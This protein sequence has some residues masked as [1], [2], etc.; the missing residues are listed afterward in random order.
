MNVKPVWPVCV[1]V[2]T[3]LQKIKHTK[4]YKYIYNMYIYIYVYIY[5]YIIYIYMMMMMNCFCGMVDRR[6]AY[7]LISS[8]DHC[9]SSSPSRICSRIWTCAEPEFST[10][11]MKLC[12]S[13]NYYTTASQI[14]I[15]IRLD[16]MIIYSCTINLNF[17]IICV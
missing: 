13:D 10:C 6:K 7:S 8:W 15:Y 3:M 9:Q 5:I 4:L 12:S 14:Y 16:N 1:C 11:W 17:I 2:A